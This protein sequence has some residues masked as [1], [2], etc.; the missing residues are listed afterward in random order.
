MD[1]FSM[2]T[3]ELNVIDADAR[4][5]HGS[6][7]RKWREIEELKDK[8]R[9]QRELQSIDINFDLNVHDISLN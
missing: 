3:E 5:R 8:Y 1:R 4:Q 6:K 7:K 9:L 2:E